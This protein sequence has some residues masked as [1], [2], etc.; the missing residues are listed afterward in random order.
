V[1]IK[2]VASNPVF[3][4][5]MQM[6]QDHFHSGRVSTII[7][8]KVLASLPAPL[9]AS[10]DVVK[11]AATLTRGYSLQDHYD[12][13]ALIEPWLSSLGTLNSL[14]TMIGRMEGD[15]TLDHLVIVFPYAEEALPSMLPMFC[16]DMAH[17]KTI[18]VPGVEN[19]Q[20]GK[21]QIA[22]LIGRTAAN[23][24]LPI[25]LGVFRSES[26]EGGYKILLQ[27][28]PPGLLMA[29]NR[30]EIIVSTDRGPAV[31]KTF[32]SGNEL[33]KVSQL[34]CKKHLEKSL[35]AW[36]IHLD[37]FIRARDATTEAEYNKKM[38]ELK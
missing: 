2:D 13:Y 14:H 5:L 4:S 25:A 28:L 17:M 23:Q 7:L 20:I 35:V 22:G 26:Y 10:V 15:F 21:L 37:Y 36:S 30:E 1:G 12:G 19:L 29:I 16:L 24:Q 11:K 33:D 3:N 27:S 34:L 6:E 31:L 18:V 38:K 9:K 8:Q 32:E